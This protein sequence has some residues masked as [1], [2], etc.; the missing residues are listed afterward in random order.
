MPRLTWYAHKKLRR[1]LWIIEKKVK[2]RKDKI[3]FS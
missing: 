3:W 1:A 2:K